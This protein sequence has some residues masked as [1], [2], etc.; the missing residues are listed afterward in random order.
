VLWTLAAVAVLAAEFARAMH[1]EAASTRNFKE[2]TRARMVAVAGINEAILAM[3]TRR[4]QGDQKLETQ[5]QQQDEE[6][7]DPVR[8]LS[9]GDGQWV[10]ATFRGNRYEVRVLDEAGKIPLNK[11]TPDQLR[12]IFKNLEIPDNDA[13][14]I[15]DSIVDWRD[16][17]DFHQPNGAESDY[18]E[19]L[20]RPYRAKN[21]NFDSVEELLLV[22]GVTREYFEGHDEVPG[23]RQIF[24]V[25]GPKSGRM[26]RDTMTPPVMQALTG[27]DRDAADDFASKRRSTE[28]DAAGQQLLDSL[29]AAGVTNTNSDSTPTDMTIEVRVFDATNQVVLSHV[30]AVVHMS[31]GGDD[32]RLRRWYDSIFDD[33]DQSGSSS[34]V[35]AEA[36]SPQG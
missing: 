8:A 4:E 16:A 30:G 32:L 24:S 13:E 11:V 34:P 21:A 18:Y 3:K 14:I 1:D 26:N 31:D 15:A 7:S 27:L 22:R 36:A 28:K 5:E 17:D 23:F 29:T 12:L 9:H 25:F 19:D 20:D 33:T 2:S 10:P 6:A 35:S